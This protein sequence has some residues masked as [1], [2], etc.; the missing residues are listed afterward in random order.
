MVGEVI[1]NYEPTIAMEGGVASGSRVGDGAIDS[2]I[3][4]ISVFLN[5]IKHGFGTELYNA[6][7][8]L[9]ILLTVRMPDKKYKDKRT[10]LIEKYKIDTDKIK[11]ITDDDIIFAKKL[12][13]AQ[14]EF[15]SRQSGKDIVGEL[16]IDDTMLAEQLEMNNDGQAISTDKE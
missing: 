14:L 3:K 11:E 9:D 16:E 6:V 1:Q 15:I 5:L 8:S 10:E 7:M 2:H 13:E 12:F 4:A